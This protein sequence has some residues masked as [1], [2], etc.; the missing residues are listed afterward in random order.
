[1]DIDYQ[2]N[3]PPKELVEFVFDFRVLK[4]QRSAHNYYK[5]ETNQKCKFN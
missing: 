5:T 1:M 3:F 4:H 2:G